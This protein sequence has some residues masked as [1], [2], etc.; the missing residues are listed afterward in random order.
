MK[1]TGLLF[2]GSEEICGV[3]CEFF[4]DLETGILYIT[5][6]LTSISGK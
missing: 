6:G 2:E 5:E 4:R 1:K 3:Y